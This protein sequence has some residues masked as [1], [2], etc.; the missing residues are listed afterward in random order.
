MHADCLAIDDNFCWD[1]EVTLITVYYM[2]DNKFL[3]TSMV[4]AFMSSSDRVFH[5]L[6]TGGK[7]N[8]CK[9]LSWLDIY[10]DGLW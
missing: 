6:I 9:H 1:Y 3:N 5:S 10:C 4:F 2:I 8:I 7:I